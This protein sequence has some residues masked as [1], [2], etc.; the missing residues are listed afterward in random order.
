VTIFNPDA[1]MNQQVAGQMDTQYIPV[2]E[3]DYAAVIDDV[4]PRKAK[5][6]AI[7]DVMWAI[8]S[9]QPVIT[10]P[11]AGKT[12]Q[13]VTG[14]PKNIVRQSIFLDLS[15]EGYLDVSKGKNIQLG[16]LREALGQNDPQRPWGPNMLK[17]Q[18]AKVT[19]KHRLADDGSGKIY[20]DVKNISR[21]G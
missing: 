17:G 7:L 13:Q 11:D 4:K 12:V 8:G 1:F 20:T 9:D 16:Q 2:P 14:L 5:D 3:S 19:V 6:S 15:P 10:G 18:M 21:L